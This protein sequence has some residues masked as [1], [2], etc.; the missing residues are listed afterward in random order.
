MGLE[1]SLTHWTR[2]DQNWVCGAAP[3]TLYT[4]FSRAHVIRRCDSRPTTTTSQTR[5]R[6]KGWPSSRESLVK[7]ATRRR[8]LDAIAPYCPPAGGGVLPTSSGRSS[9]PPFAFFFG[10]CACP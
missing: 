5:R 6:P 9:F 2:A 3:S 7:D 4:P 8:E 1:P 10:S